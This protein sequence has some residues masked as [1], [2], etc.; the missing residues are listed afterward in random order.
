MTYDLSSFEARA[1]EVH[2]WLQ[3]EFATIRTGR[4]TTA[5]LDNVRVDS[6][7]AQVP[8]NQV[9]NIN[10]EDPRTLAISVWNADQAQDVERALLDADLGLS[11]NVSD[12]GIRVSFPELTAERREQLMKLAKQKLEE[13]RIS[14]RT[15]RDEAIKQMEA[16]ELSK[17]EVFRAKETL[18]K[19]VDDFNKQ[20]ETL[21]ET[22]EKEIQI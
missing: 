22:K 21:Y 12:S 7:G 6:Y 5:L 16:D 3:K 14:L 8:L 2:E 9:A 20:M 10:V 1:K 15:A 4:A 19:K 13:G 11:V 18:Q 17:D